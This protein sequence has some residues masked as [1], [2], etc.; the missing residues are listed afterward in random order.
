VIASSVSF[1]HAFSIVHDGATP[2]VDEANGGE[3]QVAV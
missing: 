3:P 1:G 2:L